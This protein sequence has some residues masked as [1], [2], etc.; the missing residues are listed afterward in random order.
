MCWGYL[1]CFRKPLN[2]IFLLSYSTISQ[3]FQQPPKEDPSQVNSLPGGVTLHEVALSWHRLAQVLQILEPAL[4]YDVALE[5]LELL[6]TAKNLAL[7]PL[8]L[9]RR[10]LHHRVLG[11]EGVL[12]PELA[13]IEIL[14]L[15]IRP[16]SGLGIWDHIHTFFSS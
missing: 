16:G 5:M 11:Q 12:L 7:G 4:Q 9:S 3:L 1:G 10:R 13:E 8:G 2:L 15:E 6:H 14:E